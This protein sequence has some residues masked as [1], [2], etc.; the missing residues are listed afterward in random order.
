MSTW[1]THLRIAE[2]VQWE[3]QYPSYQYFLI[4]NVASDSGKINED[5]LTYNPSKEISHFRDNTKLKWRIEDLRYYRSYIMPRAGTLSSADEKS[6]H[7]GYFTHLIVDT[8]WAYFI[9]RPIK[10]K[11]KENFEKD[12][13]FELEVKRDRQ[14]M[15][16]EYLH[17]NKNLEVFEVFKHSF[18]DLNCLEH[19]PKKY[20]QDRL[21]E[22]KSEFDVENNSKR[23]NIFLSKRDWEL[24]ILVASK[25]V[26]DI[27]NNLEEIERR[28]SKS[29]MEYLE[30]KYNIFADTYGDIRQAAYELGVTFNDISQ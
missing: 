11:F 2:A 5:M 29:A 1:V 23:Q 24:S 6:F 27:L 13:Y 19:F 12:P 20:I 22:I 9:Y 15:D 10:V 26:L 17:E 28:Y 3:K 14:A 21:K 4:G 18:Y 30:E 16:A 8:L 25:L 7:Y